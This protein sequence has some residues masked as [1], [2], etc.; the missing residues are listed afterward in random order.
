MA[1]AVAASVVT[2]RGWTAARAMGDR[3]LLTQHG[4]GDSMLDVVFDAVGAVLV[5]VWGTG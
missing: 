1:F 2:R 5:A 3:A 4:L